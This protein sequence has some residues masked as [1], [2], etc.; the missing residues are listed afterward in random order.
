MTFTPKF[1]IDNFRPISGGPISP[2]DRA[3]VVTCGDP[4]IMEMMGIIH[5]LL[6]VSEYSFAKSPI[7]FWNRGNVRKNMDYPG[8]GRKMYI[9]DGTQ[10]FDTLWFGLCL[11]MVQTNPRGGH[12]GENDDILLMTEWLPLDVGIRS[13][14]QAT[15]CFWFWLVALSSYIFSVGGCHVQGSRESWWMW[16]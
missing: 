14:E 11:K 3:Y 16:L 7:G 6:E 5:S 13:L 10:H 8:I 1:T 4:G 15:R 12:C 2:R 9:I